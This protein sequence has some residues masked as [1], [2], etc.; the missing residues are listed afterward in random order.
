MYVSDAYAICLICYLLG[1]RLS[2]AHSYVFVDEAQDISLAEYRLLRAINHE[3]AFNLFGD[4]PSR[5]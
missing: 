2:P 5:P 1:R 4:L 3:A